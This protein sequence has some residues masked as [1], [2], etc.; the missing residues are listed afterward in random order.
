MIGANS[1]AAALQGR[2]AMQRGGAGK[3]VSESLAVGT[4]DY[5]DADG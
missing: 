5:S 4:V 2:A 3:T 1:P